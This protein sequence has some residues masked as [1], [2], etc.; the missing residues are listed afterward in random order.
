MVRRSCDVPRVRLRRGGPS[1]AQSTVNG[2]WGD[3]RYG[4]DRFVNDVKLCKVEG[5][6]LPVTPNAGES[7]CHL[8]GSVARRVVDRL[9]EEQKLMAARMFARKYTAAEVGGAIGL[10]ASQAQATKKHLPKIQM[11]RRYTEVMHM[12]EIGLM[13]TKR[14][15]TT[16]YG[17][18]QQKGR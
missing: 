9:T 10:S 5:C 13:K 12:E 15:W 18:I 11:L 14:G 8:H 7:K 17:Q 16:L 3:R 6:V 1:K 4:E 2:F